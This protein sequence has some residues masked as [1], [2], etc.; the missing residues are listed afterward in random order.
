MI[1][2]I[3]VHLDGSSE[4]EIRLEH[5]QFLASAGRA[6]LIGL[7]TN[8]LPD[9]TVAMPMDGGAAAIQILTELQDQAM[10]DGDAKAKWLK[11]RWADLQVP[12]E[13][14]RLDESFGVLTGK[15][16]KQARCADLFIATRPYGEAKSAV[17]PEL[18][19]AVLF[20]SGRAMLLVAPGQHRQ[21]PFETVLVAWNGSRES[22]RAL[23]EGLGFI[24][25]AS[26][27][28]VLVVD[29]PTD[30]MP[31]ADLK[32]HLAHHNV[33]AEVVTA[34]SEDRPIAEI[35]LEEAR[36]ISADLVIMGAYGHTRLREQVF[37]G[38]TRDMLTTSES[39]ILVAH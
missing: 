30:G 32:A 31:C 25:Q 12:S 20:G 23:R 29:P 33:V 21:G 39:P 34:G 28:V 36:R 10:R 38:A 22:A 27:T 19:E 1:K 3:M 5:G 2:D 9:L 24:E 37:G 11:Q 16:V 14:R 4:D 7:F 6:Q 17:W 18:V 13:L 26:R 8:Q 15:V 35:I